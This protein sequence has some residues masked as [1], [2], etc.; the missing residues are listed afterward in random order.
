MSLLDE[1]GSGDVDL[2]DL[3]VEMIAEIRGADKSGM[4]ERLMS[5]MMRLMSQVRF[6]ALIK[7]ATLLEKS[8]VPLGQPEVQSAIWKYE[9]VEVHVFGNGKYAEQEDGGIKRYAYNLSEL[10][11]EPEPAADSVAWDVWGVNSHGNSYVGANFAPVPMSGIVEMT[12]RLSLDPGSI[13]EDNIVGYTF[14]RTGVHD[15]TCTTSA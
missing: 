11:H 8:N 9:F 5:R 15:G 2:G 10:V 7:N 14:D 3:L 13:T 12:S 4:E 6:P 1:V